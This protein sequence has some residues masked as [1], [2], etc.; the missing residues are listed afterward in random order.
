[1][2]LQH[3]KPNKLL[4]VI[5]IDSYFKTKRIEVTTTGFTNL[6]GTNA[7]GKTTFLKLQRIFYGDMPSDIAKA[8]GKIR[9]SFVDYYLPRQSSYIIFEYQNQTGIKQV[10]CFA[11]KDIVTYLF[12]DKGYDLSD[13]VGGDML[14]DKNYSIITC[15][16]IYR[17]FQLADVPCALAASTKDYRNIILGTVSIKD[18][19]LAPIRQ[20]Y[21]L[22]M[23]GQKLAMLN[24]VVAASLE[25]TTDFNQIKEMLS[26]IILDGAPNQLEFNV[27]TQNI[28]KWQA[29]YRALTAIEL[30]N[31]KTRDELTQTISLIELNTQRLTQFKRDLLKY[32]RS[33]E[34]T[35]SVNAESQSD[36]KIL[37][38]KVKYALDQEVAE[39]TREYTL[40]NTEEFNVKSLIGAIEDQK[41]NWEEKN[42]TFLESEL[43]KKNQYELQLRTAK[44]ELKSLLEEVQDV[45]GKY[46]ILREK[47]LVQFNKS[48]DKLTATLQAKKDELSRLKE[49]Q[50]EARTNLAFEQQKAVSQKTTELEVNKHN[51]INSTLRLSEKLQN[52][53]APKHLT[54]QLAEQNALYLNESKQHN[55]LTSQKLTIDKDI[56][57]HNQAMQSVAKK[58]GGLDS[59]LKA[60]REELSRLNQ[61]LK[62]TSGTLHEFIN[63]NVE[64]WQSTLGKVINPDVMK[65]R[66][67]APSYEPSSSDTLFGLSLDIEN[68][69]SPYD[70]KEE[71]VF[72]KVKQCEIEIQQIEE[73][74]LAIQDKM[75]KFT[76][77]I[78]DLTYKYSTLA[79]QITSVSLRISSAELSATNTQAQIDIERE[80]LQVSYQKE[81][82]SANKNL[83]DHEAY[84]VETLD[85]IN[86]SFS[87]RKNYLLS[88]QSG[89]TSDLDTGIDYVGDSINIL[90][91]EQREAIKR[92]NDDEKREL[93]NSGID[94]NKQET[95]QTEITLHED[96][97]DALKGYPTI[98]QD[99][100]SWLKRDYSQLEEHQASY[101]KTMKK[102]IAYKGQLESAGQKLIDVK[103]KHQGIRDELIT[104][105]EALEKKYNKVDSISALLNDYDEAQPIDGYEHAFDVIT[106]DTRSLA[107]DTTK[108]QSKTKRLVEDFIHVVNPHFD[109]SIKKSIDE[110]LALNQFDPYYS[111]LGS[112]LCREFQDVMNDTR[113]VIIELAAT[114]GGILIGYYEQLKRFEAEINKFGNRVNSHLENR[115]VFTSLGKISVELKPLLNSLD[116]FNSLNRFEHLHTK[117][118][119][120]RFGELPDQQYSASMSE[121]L[122]NFSSSKLIE[123]HSNLYDVIFHAEVN[124]ETHSARTGNELKEISS[125]G[126]SYLILLSFISSIGN[127]IKGNQPVCVTYPVDEL[128]DI[129]VENVSALFDMFKSD[130]D[131]LITA[132]PN[133]D[134]NLVSLYHKR[135][136][137]NQKKNRFEHIPAGKSDLEILLEEGA[138]NVNR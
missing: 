81:L 69:E 33:F 80:R 90:N 101:T 122:D 99:Y 132:L 34:E 31:K 108:A 4:R 92:L 97:L 27:D 119:K 20:K 137:V 75:K 114:R 17:K 32:K 21:S 138:A 36:N 15:E 98:L 52:I 65:L 51:F 113:E 83:R 23:R 91:S 72:A 63:D 37:W 136:Y 102:K 82:D 2:N 78:Q 46:S 22:A 104:E 116:L 62:P 117:W 79:S 12:V 55:E 129:S 112:F 73:E 110:Q 74:K 40:L 35:L 61:L 16:H 115:T 125:N 84:C 67:L 58:Q 77:S 18:K 109:S 130:G 41:I 124:G 85:D 50:T 38:R 13:Y 47:R 28:A 5:L 87:T 105:S 70:K 106:A 89:E 123:Y 120:E 127:L 66:S 30:V 9:K 95:L 93:S 100:A 29:D 1:M 57:S 6:S 133:A 64:N 76:K 44:Y 45:Q 14:G 48:K 26:S 131:L 8:R 7:A 3:P 11:R 94:N 10:V 53:P 121:V 49:K 128:G 86:G 59:S 24:T 42:V 71:E 19:K 68:I 96:K 54:D 107:Q 103:R 88:S 39:L 126:M 60:A 135:Y 111:A 25:R 134:N 118:T 43:A 56:V